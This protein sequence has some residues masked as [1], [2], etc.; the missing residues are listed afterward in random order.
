M[1][2]IILFFLAFAFA[3]IRPRAVSS[4]TFYPICQLQG[5]GNTTP[6]AGEQVQTEGMVTADFD[7][8]SER[9]FFIQVENCD[10][11]GD[12]SN[13][14]FVYLNEMAN[15]VSVGDW[16]TVSGLAEEDFGL[17]RINTTPLG[18]GVVSSGNA[19]PLAVDFAPPFDNAQA[20]TYFERHESMRVYAADTV[21]VGPTSARGYA[22][23]IRAGLGIARVFQGDPA[24]TG[25][26]I[27]ISSDGVYQIEP[28]AQVG[29][30]VFNVVGVL[31]Y[32]SGEFGIMLTS[33]PT[34]IRPSLVV[35]HE[36]ALLPHS[37]AELQTTVHQTNQQTAPFSLATLNLH[38]LFDPIDD[39]A[40]DDSIPT[41]G[42]YQTHLKK[43]AL[44]IHELG[45]PL[46]IAVQ[47]AENNS[48]LQALA[49]RPELEATYAYLWQDSVDRRGIDVA[50][51]YQANRVNVIGWEL[52][53]GCTTLVDG[54]GPDGNGDV[55]L[56]ANA[57]T[58]DTDG[59]GENDGNRLFSRPPL[60]AHVQVCEGSCASGGALRDLW[61]IAVHFKSKSED[62][63]FQAYTLPRRMAQA[64]FVAGVYAEIVGSEPG[65]EVIAA[66]DFNDYPDSQ[67]LQILAGAGFVDQVV[68]VPQASAFTYNFEGVSQIID[69][70]LVSPGVLDNAS[71]GLIPTI[72]HL[73]ADYPVSWEGDDSTARRATDH[74]PVVLRVGELTE[75]VWLP[76]VARP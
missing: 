74:D 16:V 11:N 67:P 41:P 75:A 58:C 14:I 60:V 66:G 6:Y 12:T 47:E 1:Q 40:T 54:L 25:E 76:I 57:L 52:R 32:T 36:S 42:E 71:Q 53:Q 5:T 70:I 26:I 27:P 72:F 34:L 44:T 28:D 15:V 21:V 45:E 64:Q 35:A 9:G 73:N 19:L 23:V 68:R 20:K 38:N 2:K 49:N 24:G 29:D 55:T 43:L 30:Q 7:N 33:F 59:D 4:A 13:G 51:L 10:D 65:A 22:Y 62:N 61:V 17:T 46:F 3:F 39:P 56:P 18:V 63:D 69:H 37:R 50:L 8:Q 31:N 48:V